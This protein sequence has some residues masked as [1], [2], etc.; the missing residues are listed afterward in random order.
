MRRLARALVVLILL[1]AGVGVVGGVAASILPDKLR[2]DLAARIAP[3]SPAIAGWLL[4][5]APP[6]DIPLPP[7]RPDWRN[8]PLNKR[9]AAGGFSRGQPVFIRILKSEALLARP[10]RQAAGWRLF[11]AYPICAY[12]GGLGPKLREGDGQSPEGF[13][14]V[15]RGAL[16]PNSSY[17]L[18]FN[19]GFPNAY[20]RAH[21]RTGSFLMVHGACSSIGCY[22]M[23]DEGIDEIYRLV[24]AALGAGQKAVPVHAFPFRM[25]EANL[26]RNA[27]SPHLPFWRNLKEGWDLFEKRGAPP[28]A[29]SCPG[30][31]YGFGDGATL[32]ASSGACRPIA[33]L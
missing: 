16:N 22:A 32:K 21:G 30:P 33:G 9:L 4:A 23:T 3:Y 5:M 7:E 8:E 25:T 27:A 18:S 12:S 6:K 31:L 24:E 13:Y 17:H 2:D 20:D 1:I 15:T 26:A 14:A 19:L 11:Q 28:A 10:M 29:H